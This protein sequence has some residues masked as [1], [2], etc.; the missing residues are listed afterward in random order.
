MVDPLTILIPYFFSCSN[1][2]TWVRI[3]EKLITQ[4]FTYDGC[5]LKKKKQ[6]ESRDDIGIVL[7][8]KFQWKQSFALLFL[9]ALRQNL[10]THSISPGAHNPPTS[11]SW[12]VEL[13]GVGRDM[14]YSKLSL[15]THN[16]ISD[17]DNL[18]SHH[19]FRFN[20]NTVYQQWWHI[21]ILPHQ[22]STKGHSSYWSQR[23]IINAVA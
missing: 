7:V 6:P 1:S 14:S 18:L 12:E 13:L 9:C 17:P 22:N 5:D 15:F 2:N 10:P 23:A 19:T 21:C 4:W 16:S 20:K 8:L 11:F 3:K